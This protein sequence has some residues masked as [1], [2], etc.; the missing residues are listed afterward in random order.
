MSVSCTHGEDSNE[1]YLF[2]STPYATFLLYRTL[3]E[4]NRVAARA[5]TTTME[6]TILTVVEVVVILDILWLL[7]FLFL[8]YERMDLSKYS[9][10]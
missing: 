6:T 8:V 5:A 7:L 2:E 1:L 3:L 9:V 10:D 4:L